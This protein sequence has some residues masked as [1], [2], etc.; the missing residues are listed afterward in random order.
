MWQTNLI[1]FYCSVSEH[2]NTMEAMTQRQSN[3][4]R[5]Q[6]S[7]EEC[8]TVYLW[9]ICQQR[10]EQ[11]TSYDYTK[12]HLL[13]CF[14][15]LPSY[16]AFSRRLNFLAPAFQALAE[17][18]LTVILERRWKIQPISSILARLFWQKG[19]VPDMQRSQGD[20]VRRVI[21]L[22]TRNGIMA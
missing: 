21:I 16:A 18:W 6:F 2:Y 10:F 14:P 22:H 5:P 11:R 3:N 1:K 19:H 12:N 9:G 7:D 8:I 4:F 17:E 13:D 15:K 20:C